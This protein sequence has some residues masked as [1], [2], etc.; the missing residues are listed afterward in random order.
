MCVSGQ[1]MTWFELWE[2]VKSCDPEYTLKKKS[3]AQSIKQFIA[4][5]SDD[6]V[7]ASVYE[8]MG[9]SDTLGLPK[10]KVDGHREK[11]FEYLKFR[12]PAELIKGIIL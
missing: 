3:L 7:A 2:L 9:H 8:V 4:K 12:T 6:K 5:E 10:G 11:F 1:Q